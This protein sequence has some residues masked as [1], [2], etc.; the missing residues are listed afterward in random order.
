MKL[1][2]FEVFITMLKFLVATGI[3]NRPYM[4]KEYGYTNSVAA[5]LINILIVIFSYYSLITCM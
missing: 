1:N 5:E 2:E 4:Y 3:F